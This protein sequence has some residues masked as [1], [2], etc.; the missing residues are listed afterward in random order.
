MG[1]V[2]SP[3]TINQRNKTMMR[4][5]KVYYRGTGNFEL[6]D[7]LSPHQA[8]LFMALKNNLPLNAIHRLRAERA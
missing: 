6:I 3:A 4:F 2:Y 1:G 5:Y 7:A 8:K